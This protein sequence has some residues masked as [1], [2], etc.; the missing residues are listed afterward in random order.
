[1][2]SF[3]WGWGKAK[4]DG[5]RGLGSLSGTARPA[6]ELLEG[7]LAP[8][9][10]L[11]ATLS[12]DT[13]TFTGSTGSD[14]SLSLGVDSVG[15]LRHNLFSQG[16]AG[17]ASDIDLD[18]TT[19]GVQAR[20]VA[21]LSGISVDTGSGDDRVLMQSLGRGALDID[22]S[23]AERVEI[24]T[25]VGDNSVDVGANGDQLDV[26]LG[27]KAFHIDGADTLVLNAQGGTDRVTVGDLSGITAAPADINIVNAERL[28]FN[29][30]DGDDTVQ[31]SRHDQAAG[32]HLDVTIGDQDFHV[33]SANRVVVD[34]EGGTDS[35]VAEGLGARFMPNVFDLTA[36]DVEVR[37]GDNGDTVTLGGNQQDRLA[38]QLGGK[39]V[40]VTADDQ[41]TLD[42]MGGTDSVRVTDLSGV[43]GMADVFIKDAAQVTVG[44]NTDSNEVTVDAGDGSL[45]VGTTDRDIHIQDAQGVRINMGAGA[46]T[47]TVNDLSSITAPTLTLDGGRGDDIYKLAPG[48]TVRIVDESGQDTLDFSAFAD[49]GINLDLAL[50][51][52][53]Q[54]VGGG[55]N[56]TLL[57]TMENVI[58][59][60]AA[61]VIFGNG[62]RNVLDGRGGDDTLHGRGGDDVLF[63]NEG[64]DHL[65]GEAGADVMIGGNG[66]DQ[67]DGGAGNNSI[68]DPD[69]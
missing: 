26:T 69:S 52:G 16:V 56:L 28:T 34:T 12:G 21:S 66:Q 33:I 62:V 22:I 68:L 47:I 54:S 60:E 35:I 55:L 61:D 38:M 13:V 29:T 42:T 65:F 64:D 15:R 18:S 30:G 43:S 27:P 51:R 2:M 59:T 67:F 57:S 50:G 46:D 11:I 49:T 3:R 41:F 37:T 44:M 6:L 7:R 9:T 8:A 32:G 4:A 48:A 40:L 25:G 19:P 20:Q 17:F 53:A 39:T 31:L 23:A 45:D 36:E 10:A 5:R 1:M 14:D 24:L 63:G 58:G